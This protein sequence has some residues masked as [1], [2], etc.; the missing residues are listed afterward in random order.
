MTKIRGQSSR[1]FATD[2]TD[3]DAGTI[4]DSA[5]RQAVDVVKAYLR[6][7]FIVEECRKAPCFGCAS[8]EAVSLER[9]LDAL[10][11]VI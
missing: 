9:R 7:E 4:S 6:Q 11:A 1:V 3:I 10:L 5:V 8:C 2:G